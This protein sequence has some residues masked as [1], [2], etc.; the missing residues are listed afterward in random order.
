MAQ[1][2]VLL[3]FSAQRFF[4]ISASVL[5]SI[6]ILYLGRALFV[7]LAFGLLISFILYPISAWLERKGF[8]RVW[9]TLVTIVSALSLL[10]LLIYVFSLK[11]FAIAEDFGGFTGKL[12]D[13]LVNI[14]AALNKL[15]F[16]GDITAQ[17]L[18]NRSEQ[19]VTNTRAHFLEGTLSATAVFFSGLALTVMYTFLILLYRSGL[20]KA[21]LG[22]ARSH[23]HGVYNGMIDSI[24]CIGKRYLTGMFTLIFILGSLN[25]VGLFAL[26]IDYALFFGF[27]AAFMAIIPYVGTIIGSAIPV[28]YALNHY[29]SMW[30]PVGVVA[31]FVFIQ[32]IDGNFLTPK[33]IGG[34]LQLNALAAVISLI[35][36]GL[37][38]GIPGMILFL[39][40]TAV[41]KEVCR[42]YRPL[43]PVTPILEDK[44][45]EP[46]ATQ[47]TIKLHGEVQRPHVEVL[48]NH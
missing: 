47:P 33:I 2:P 41:L 40:Y 34:N 15:P 42:C 16:A 28:L 38:W 25:T 26:G 17:E 35:A 32:F 10:L 45:Y 12:N 43:N 7:P 18:L 9:S 14:A 23:K 36:G 13:L 39:P 3:N 31:I 6:I 46:T 30:Y 29:D 11:F 20:R 37:L 8:T 19:W 5:M 48:E 44:L 27:L 1:R 21:F 4:F 22:F 24:Q